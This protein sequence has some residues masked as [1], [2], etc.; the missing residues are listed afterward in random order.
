M[1]NTQAQTVD[2]VTVRSMET[3]ESLAPDAL[4]GHVRVTLPKMDSDRAVQEA[5]EKGKAE[6]QAAIQSMLE[7]VAADVYDNVHGQLA[8]LQKKQVEKAKQMVSSPLP[9]RPAPTDA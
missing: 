2:G 1:G 3:E 7:A 4:G 9:P 6:G 8:E 5:Y